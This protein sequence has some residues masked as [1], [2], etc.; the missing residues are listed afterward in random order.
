M[1]C[2]WVFIV[3][4]ASGAAPNTY[5]SELVLLQIPFFDA[6]VPGAAEQHVALHGQTLQAVIVGRLEVVGG[7]YVTHGSL[8]HIK[9]LGWEGREGLS[10]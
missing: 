4:M 3:S 5:L 10:D 1:L 8:G 9:H 6:V 7:A 2:V